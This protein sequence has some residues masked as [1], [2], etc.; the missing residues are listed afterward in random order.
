MAYEKKVP[1]WQTPALN[2][3]MVSQL[4]AT[5]DE[6]T[7]YFKQRKI[8]PDALDSCLYQILSDYFLEYEEELLDKV[9]RYEQLVQCWYYTNLRQ[10]EIELGEAAHPDAEPHFV[11]FHELFVVR[12]ADRTE[13]ERREILYRMPWHFRTLLLVSRGNFYNEAFVHDVAELEVLTGFSMD[14]VSYFALAEYDRFALET[15][16]DDIRLEHQEK[17]RQQLME[18]L[19]TM[20][21]NFQHIGEVR[22]E[23]VN[24]GSGSISEA[25]IHGVSILFY[26]MKMRRE[27]QPDETQRMPL[28][29]FALLTL[30]ALCFWHYEAT[31][32]QSSWM[33]KEGKFRHLKK[34][35]NLLHRQS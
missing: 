12:T 11:R 24:N 35:R 5:R 7:I 25:D 27:K 20:I 16:E 32:V 28:Y 10:K 2:E 3:S 13:D 33:I 9:D 29:H 19:P 17:I 21:Y 34:I 26:L 14:D 18:N 6:A 23:I 4:V 8:E 30:T 22:E 1:T 15:I 31:F